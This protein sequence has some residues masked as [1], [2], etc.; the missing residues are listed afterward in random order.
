MDAF[1]AQAPLLT[2]P[3]LQNLLRIEFA[4]ARRYSYP[5][6]CLVAQVDGIERLRDLHGSGLRDE[7]VRRVVAA[8]R[9]QTRASDSL[10]VYQDRIAILLPHT[11]IEGAG[12]A[13]ERLRTAVGREVFRAGGAELRL[14]VSAGL[15]AFQE[16][17]TIFFD[18][19]LKAAEAALVQAVTAG[20]DRVVVAAPSPAPPA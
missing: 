8:V 1:G 11:T 2:Y 14:T 12:S 9:T 17:G 3:Q 5:L 15:A 7:I 20:G 18:S 4:R 16:R 13:A 6:C 10:G 19:V